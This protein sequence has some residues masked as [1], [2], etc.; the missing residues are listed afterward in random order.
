LLPLS[1]TEY[2]LFGTL[3]GSEVAYYTAVQGYEFDGYS[4]HTLDGPRLLLVHN[5]SGA[6]ARG[7]AL[8]GQIIT[9]T[10]TE[11]GSLFAVTGDR[12]VL[13]GSVLWLS[14]GVP[15]CRPPV[16]VRHNITS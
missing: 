4:G 3:D 11:N 12:S 1:F 16:A 13:G 9:A 6:Q 2:D 5:L 8:P 10:L 7:M 14:Y 15:D